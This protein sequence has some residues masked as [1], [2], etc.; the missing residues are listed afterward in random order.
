MGGQGEQRTLRLVAQYADACNLMN[1]DDGANL[2]HKLDVLRRHCDA[3]GRDYD[4][5]EKTCML[6]INLAQKKMVN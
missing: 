1:G 5:I 6:G 2:E 3:L 4:S